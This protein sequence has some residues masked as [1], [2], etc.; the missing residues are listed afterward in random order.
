MQTLAQIAIF[1]IQSL[2]TLYVSL[3]LLRFLLQLVRADY[4]NPISKAL[5]KATNPLLVPLRKIIPGFA[6]MDLAALVLALLLQ[7]VL[8]QVVVLLAGA[9]FVNILSLLI[10]AFFGLLGL[11]LSV[12]YYGMFVI[13]IASWVAPHSHNPALNLLQQLIE[14]VVAPFRKIL[15]PLGV[16]DLSPMIF[17]MVLHIIRAYL[18]P[19][20]AAGVG[21]PAGLVMGI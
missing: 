9:G 1:I 20:L 4:Y 6:G 17:L 10:W 16:I 13:I 7:A 11:T 19:N 14:P 21:L 5:V 2:G 8:I 12:Y 18:L 3:V 15:P